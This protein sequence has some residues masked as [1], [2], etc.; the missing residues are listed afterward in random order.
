MGVTG[1]HLRIPS[2]WAVEY[3]VGIKVLQQTITDWVTVPP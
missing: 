3:G 1:A 2:V